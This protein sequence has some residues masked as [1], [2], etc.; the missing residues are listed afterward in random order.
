M[1]FSEIQI[2]ITA[3][4][5][6]AAVV[7]VVLCNLLRNRKQQRGVSNLVGVE[8]SWH[9]FEPSADPSSMAPEIAALAAAGMREERT[10]WRKTEPRNQ[11]QVSKLESETNAL[12]LPPPTIDEFLFDLLVSGRSMNNPLD[13]FGSDEHS[14]ECFA[15]QYQVFE[16]TTNGTKTAGMIDESALHNVIDIGGPFTG[17]VVSI[18]INGD[19][20]G[21][22]GERPLDWVSSFVSGL[23]GEND[24]ACRTGEEEFLIVCPGVRG[25]QA[26]RRL[27]EIS[28]GLWEFQLREIGTCSILFSWG[29]VRVQDQPLRDAIET[30]SERMR[31]T[32]RG[33]HPIYSD[34][35][36]ARRQ[37]V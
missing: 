23:L 28:E 33:R 16:P 2:S 4:F 1:E 10:D 19:E 15:S 3:L 20:S 26:Q 13:G 37:V 5:L 30:A 24:L 8:Q 14:A 9:S 31:L 22:R 18:C 6:L 27:N 29:G 11:P 35:M 34:A 17:V 12:Q 36:N 7:I 32:K 25:A 21:P